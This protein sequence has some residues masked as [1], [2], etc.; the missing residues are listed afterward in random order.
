MTAVASRRVLVTGASGFVGRFVP[1]RLL[2]Q[3]WEVH[4]LVRS[5]KRSHAAWAPAVAD[6]CVFHEFDLLSHQDWRRVSSIGATHLMHLAWIATPGVYWT[7]LENLDWVAASLQLIR[8][9]AAGGGKR[10]V[11]AGSCAEYDWGS[12]TLDERET[13]IAPATLYGTAKGALTALT[14]AA[15]PRLGVSAAS[16]TIFFPFGPFENAN[17]LL[18]D[19]IGALLAGRDASCSEGRQVRDF[20]YVED[21]AAAFVAILASDVQGRVNV[22]SGE[23]KTVRE[24]VEL[25]ARAIGREDLLRFG[26]RPMAENDPPCLIAA[27]NRL[28]HEVGFKPN[29][30]FSQG[31]QRTIDWWRGRDLA[32][33][34]AEG[35]S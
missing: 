21:M 17:R 31:M 27:T 13:K 8:S 29:F 34:E 26:A 3:G 5:A 24:A 23:G 28:H 33:Q 32:Q 20:L 4:L 10:V 25:T 18:P 15:A 9:F 30:T 7:S 16:G 35:S 14:L 1:Q 22:G 12:G 19:V 2:D 11:V 6:Q